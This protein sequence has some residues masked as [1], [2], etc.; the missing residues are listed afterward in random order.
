MKKIYL[1]AQSQFIGEPQEAKLL[2]QQLKERGIDARRLSRFTQLNLLA[3][4]PLK[5]KISSKTVLYLGSPFSSPSTFD[6]MFHNLMEQDLPSPLDFMANVS[7]AAIFHIA[8]QFQLENNCSF[9]S[10][11]QNNY[12][13]PLWLAI[14]DLLQGEA[15]TALVG[16]GLEHSYP[17]Q[18]EGVIWW[19]ISTNAENSVDEINIKNIKE[20]TKSIQTQLFENP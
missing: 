7:N 1:T 8:Q 5:E 14:N 18:K 12:W 9:I 15:E 6:K 20:H 10:I 11:N 3:V 2:R 16:W 4:L 13:Q 17:N 19:L